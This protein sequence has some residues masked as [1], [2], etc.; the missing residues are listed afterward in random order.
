M[1][2]YLDYG[3]AAIVV[4]HVSTVVEVHLLARAAECPP[5]GTRRFGAPLHRESRS[6]VIC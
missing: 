2:R 5:K 4:T 1:G 6:E 3:T